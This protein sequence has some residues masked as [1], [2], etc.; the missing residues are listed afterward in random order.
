MPAGAESLTPAVSYASALQ[1]LCF[2]WQE[3]GGGAFPNLPMASCFLS[4]RSINELTGPL[5]FPSAS[6]LP[7]AQYLRLLWL[8]TNILTISN[9]NPTYP[10]WWSS[11]PGGMAWG[12]AHGKLPEG[13]E[14]RERAQLNHGFMSTILN[15]CSCV[16]LSYLFWAEL[17]QVQDQKDIVF[18]FDSAHLLPT[19]SLSSACHTCL[20]D[21]NARQ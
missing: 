4:K 5:S 11:V 15:L 18:P 19:K 17:C 1:R 16:C 13:K 8:R 2:S 3:M 7:T 9:S 21:T 14:R 10:C 20:D 12:R 6:H